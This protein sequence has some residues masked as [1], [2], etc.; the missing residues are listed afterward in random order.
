MRTQ[1]EI[2]ALESKIDFESLNKSLLE[3]LERGD[4]GRRKT[5]NTLLDRIGDTLLELRRRQVPLRVIVQ[6]LKKHG[7]IVSEGRVRAYLRSRG[8]TRPKRLA[9]TR[10]SGQVQRTLAKRPT[11][12]GPRS[13]ATAEPP[14]LGL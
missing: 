3:R 1:A 5:T 7:L 4:L 12:A 6:E 9:A 8:V 10:K 14:S 11:T 13:G 2:L